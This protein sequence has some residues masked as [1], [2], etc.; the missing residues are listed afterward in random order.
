MRR[1]EWGVRGC[2]LGAASIAAVT[3]VDVATAATDVDVAAAAEI[4]VAVAIAAGGAKEIEALSNKLNQTS[5]HSLIP[6][7][8][9]LGLLEE[10]K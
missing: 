3:D 2:V 9:Y 6:F 7:S 1:G 5:T 10:K 4:S 8:V